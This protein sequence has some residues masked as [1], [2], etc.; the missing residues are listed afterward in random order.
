MPGKRSSLSQG[1]MMPR[2]NNF[3]TDKAHL[4][5][6]AIALYVDAL[7]FDKVYH[8]PSVILSHVADC[9]ECKMEI[10]EIFSLLQGPEIGGTETH[11]FL[12]E[13]TAEGEKEFS[14]AFR[15]AAVLVIG[16]SIGLVSYYFRMLLE[17]HTLLRGSIVT[18]EYVERGK[19][20]FVPSDSLVVSK[21]EFFAD[22][23]TVSPNLENLVN[24]HSRS[25]SIQVLSPLNGENFTERILFQWKADEDDRI[26]LKILSNKEKTLR[27]ISVRGSRYAF[28]Q[29]IPPG[30]Y[31]WKLESKDELLYLGKFIVK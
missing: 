1:L 26:T 10:V 8:L 16:I 5:D 25:L 15:V 7:K 2:V 29:K 31:Y 30:L 21:Q 13:K 9:R 17:E 3:F 22:N 20:D 19:Q 24:A 6:E 27:T 28:S 11:P 18:R 23:F 14:I 4:S 12:D